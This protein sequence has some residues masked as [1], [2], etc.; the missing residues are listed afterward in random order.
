MSIRQMLNDFDIVEKSLCR[1]HIES[2]LN[3][4]KKKKNIIDAFA[5]KIIN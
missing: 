4:L 2:P 3:I 1:H 5:V